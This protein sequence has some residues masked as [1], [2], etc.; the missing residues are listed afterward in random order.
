M[1]L[2][3]IASGYLDK[4]LRDWSEFKPWLIKRF[5]QLLILY[6]SF[7]ILITIY[8]IFVELIKGNGFEWISKNVLNLVLGGNYVSGWF[9]IFWFVTC[10]FATQILFAIIHISLKSN[11]AR[12]LLIG[13][14]YLFAHVE[15]RLVSSYDIYIPWN[16]DVALFTI[17]YYAFGYYLRIFIYTIF[18][19]KLIS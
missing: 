19:N 15:A 12:F 5:K 11:S 8:K 16:I 18:Y 3:F 2:F 4:G 9:S 17:V 14:F 1:S 10:L 13:I 7:I 6:T